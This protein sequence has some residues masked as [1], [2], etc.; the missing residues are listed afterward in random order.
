MAKI[1]FV[2]TIPMQ[3]CMVAYMTAYMATRQDRIRIITTKIIL[4]I[5]S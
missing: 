2:V 1:I 3:S 4:A 5:L